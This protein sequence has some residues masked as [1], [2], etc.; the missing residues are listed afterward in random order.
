MSS[1]QAEAAP[2]RHSGAPP[3]DLVN[4]VVQLLSRAVPNDVDFLRAN[5]LGRDEFERAFPAAIEKIRGSK[6]ASNRESRRVVELTIKHLAD[7]GAISS[8]HVPKKGES[9]VYRLCLRNGRQ[10]GVIQKGCPDGAHSSTAW[11]RPGWADELYLWW[12]CD[13][14]KFEPG[15]HIWKGVTRVRKKVAEEP[16]N[17]LDGVIFFNHL[18]GSPERLCPKAGR[19]TLASGLELPPPCVYVFPTW[20]RGEEELNWRGQDVRE[21]PRELMSAFGVEG[22][23]WKDNVGY[24]GF[25]VSGRNVKTEITA[26][27]GA[28]KASSVRR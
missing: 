10:I 5:G 8:Y 24:V 13:S 9:T 22:S 3:E 14:L 20:K 16:S 15:E 18:C 27:Y 26:R 4:Q 19:V 1:D 28:A 12:A 25:R 21:F 11:E 23:G 7:S 2:C 6:A 17:Q